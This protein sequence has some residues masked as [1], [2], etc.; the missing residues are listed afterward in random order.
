MNKYLQTEIENLRQAVKNL[1]TIKVDL[2]AAHEKNY[3]AFDYTYDLKPD[4]VE[5]KINF[6]NSMIKVMEYYQEKLG[7]REELKIGKYVNVSIS[8]YNG[9]LYLGL[10]YGDDE[11]EGKL[12][13]RVFGSHSGIN[14]FVQD[15]FP[16]LFSVMLG[17]TGYSHAFGSYDFKDVLRVFKNFGYE[18]YERKSICYSQKDFDKHINSAKK[19][20]DWLFEI[21]S[22]KDLIEDVDHVVGTYIDTVL[23]RNQEN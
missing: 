21:T 20:L 2:S 5:R 10:Y 4:N 14:E 8:A 23:R 12:Y 3:R 16:D 17:S 6:I 9:S 7:E 19:H 13:D 18:D 11:T 15:H 1:E 22:N